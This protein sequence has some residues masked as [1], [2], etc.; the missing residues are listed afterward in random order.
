MA[1][2]SRCRFPAT[3]R[4]RRTYAR[5]RGHNHNGGDAICEFSLGLDSFSGGGDSFAE[6]S[7]LSLLTY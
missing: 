2:R 1:R 5:K 3:M 6:R 4:S 7:R